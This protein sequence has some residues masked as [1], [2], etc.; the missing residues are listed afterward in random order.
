MM[1]RTKCRG[2][3]VL[4]ML[5]ALIGSSQVTQASPLFLDDFNLG[6][7]ALWNN[8]SG[9]WSAAGGVYGSPVV[10][11]GAHSL[12]E[13]ALTDFVLDV[14]VS[15]I[16]DGG[17]WLRAAPSVSAI[18]VQG[19]LLVTQE[20]TN[21]L[22]WHVIPDGGSWGSQINAVSTPL[23]AVGGDAHLTIRVIDD[24]FSVFVNGNTTAA[25]TLMT[26]LFT[27]GAVGLYANSGQ[28]FDDVEINAVPEPGAIVLVASGLMG[29]ASRRWRRRL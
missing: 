1:S 11:N 10:P 27:S 2:R 5:A 25:T 17:I 3:V 8:Q 23:F 14:N 26:S 16:E 28:N 22:F 9:A 13:F 18:G 29:L 7:S 15:D 12:L 4:A 19:V 6:A 24:V 20:F 21:S